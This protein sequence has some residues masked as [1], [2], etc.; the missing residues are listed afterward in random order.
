MFYILL[1]GIA[2][3]KKILS[4]ANKV[5]MTKWDF[6]R[7][8]GSCYMHFRSDTV[9]YERTVVYCRVVSLN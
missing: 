9:C 8:L 2:A 7:I 5:T 3:Q 1:T 6:V 4:V